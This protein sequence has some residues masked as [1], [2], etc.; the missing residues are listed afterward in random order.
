MNQW[1][2]KQ[3][4]P[5]L[6]RSGPLAAGKLCVCPV[7]FRVEHVGPGRQGDSARSEGGRGDE[8]IQGLSIILSES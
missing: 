4:K 6:D 7:L 8:E 5:G 2:S 3:Q 1:T